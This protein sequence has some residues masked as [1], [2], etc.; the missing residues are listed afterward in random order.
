MLMNAKATKIYWPRR[1]KFPQIFRR[2]IE[3]AGDYYTRIIY[4]IATKRR[5]DSIAIPP[6]STLYYIIDA[7]MMS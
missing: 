5:A 4:G 1:L 3:I 6:A 7:F 2:M